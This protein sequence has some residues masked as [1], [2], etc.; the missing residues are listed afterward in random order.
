MPVINGVYTKDFPAL[1]RAPIDTDIIPIAEVANQITFKTTIG[2]I[3]N[4]K[5]F[6]TT[7]AIPKFTSGNTLGDSI[8]TEL[9]DKI[10]VD[11]ATPNNKLSINSTDPGSGLDLQIGATSYARFGIINPGLPG[12]P[13]VDNDCFIGSTINNDF[14]VR[15]NNIEALRIDTAQRLTIANIQ[16]ALAD[17]DKFLVSEGGVI[18]YRTGAEVLTDIGAV[19]YT[20]ATSDVDLGLFD[21]TATALIKAGGVNTQ[22]L[23]ADGS[24]DNNNYL[25]AN[26]LP[27]TLS[28]YATNVPASVSGYFK[29]VT[30]I[31]DPDFNT[32]AVDISTGAITT[33]NQL[34]ASLVSPTNLING[35]PG[36]FNVTTIGNIRKVS[37]SGQAEFYFEAYKRTSAGV[38]T[39]VATSSPTLPVV[40]STYAEFSATA[41]WNDGT[42]GVTDTIVLKF[43]GVRIAGGSNPIYD[44]QFGGVSPVRTFVPIPTAVIPN[45]YLEQ[46]EDVEDGTASNN[47]GIFFD[48]SVS[49]WKYKSVSEVLGYTPVSGTGTA[50]Y[51]PKFNGTSSLT[52]STI[53]E[54]AGGVAIGVPF[55]DPSFLFYVNGG[56][57][58][59]GNSTINGNLTASQFIVPGGTSSQFLKAN[60]SLDST[61]YVTLS[62]NQTIDGEKTFTAGNIFI[63]SRAYFAE[64]N[65][66]SAI[67]GYTQMI[68]LANSFTFINGAASKAAVFTYAN[69][70]RSYILPST[71]GTLALSSELSAYLPLTGGTLTGP[72]GGTSATFNTPTI[73]GSLTTSI[74]SQPV[75]TTHY[76]NNRLGNAYLTGRGTTG[77]T[78]ISSNTNLFT[79]TIE[80]ASSYLSQ[81]AGVLSFFN[82]ASV[83]AGGT[84]TFVQRLAIDSNGNT[85]IGY[86]TNPS[87]YKL[88]VN[89][90]GRFSGA[91]SANN[92]ITIGNGVT[93]SN[94]SITLLGVSGVSY[95]W[96]ITN[97]A[98]GLSFSGAVNPSLRLNGAT[99]AA[100]FSSSV[101]TGAPSGGTAKPFKVGNVATVTPTSPNR[102][103]E[104]E[105]DGTTYYLTAKTTND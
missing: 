2:A 41:L 26:D 76:V 33:T 3:F 13:G 98:N 48:S 6:G 53:Y 64:D 88:D 63:D 7:G 25:T 4:A 46:L 24:V 23:K 72:L 60:G 73:S 21:I 18:K 83:S 40:N 91:L 65:G 81:S 90:T 17:T 43:Y 32:T 20:G 69:G 52:N 12:E 44:F 97:D 95:T 22:F 75:T 62:S 67:A 84:P 8:I 14:L 79:T 93:A 78:F 37:G 47:D 80:G 92:S 29:L 16:N 102:T 77:E 100:T 61:A 42:F 36:V 101:T 71:S 39:L 1:G 38:E 30:T 10:G 87:L 54:D 56:I 66:Q 94:S 68:T 11:I 89:G 27:S 99:G 105:I 86:T 85:A 55:S 31:D 96:G 5:V 28:L 19:P 49:L 15:T 104:I 57:G 45:I 59:N 103:I 35:N 9:S 34:I 51:I 74:N 82:A 70:I 50:N 58:A